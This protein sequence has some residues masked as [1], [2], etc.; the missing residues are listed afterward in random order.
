MTSKTTKLYQEHHVEFENWFNSVHPNHELNFQWVSTHDAGWYKED[1]AN[2]AWI[3]WL[4]LTG[5]YTSS[6]PDESHLPRPATI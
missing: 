5:K 4:A 6:S 1:M 3:A 2:G